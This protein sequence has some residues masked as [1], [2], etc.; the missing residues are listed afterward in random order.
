MKI[1]TLTARL[2]DEYYERVAAH[3]RNTNA[4][5]AKD[6]ARDGPHVPWTVETWLIDV[7]ASDIQMDVVSVVIHAE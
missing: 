4:E 7:I 1:I 3:V 5:M 2:T 6:D